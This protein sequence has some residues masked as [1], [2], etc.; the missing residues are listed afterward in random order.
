MTPLVPILQDAAAWPKALKALTDAAGIASAALIISNKPTGGVDEA[1]FSGLSAEFKSDYVNHYAAIDP[2]SPLLDGKWLKLSDRVPA[3]VLRKSEWYNHFVLTCGVRDILV[4][5]LV[6]TAD[7]RAIFGIHQQIGGSFSG[8]LDMI[9]DRLS[10][11]LKHAAFRY[12]DRRDPARSMRSSETTP[13]RNPLLFPHRLRKLLP[14]RSLNS[15]FQQPE[16]ARSSP[17]T[18]RRNLRRTMAGMDFW[19]S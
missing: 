11:P 19:F 6:D 8:K 7:Q 2:Y 14:G 5:R 10:I 13:R 15:L 3:A 17:T 12:V 16:T 9:V 4:V 1:C 18:S